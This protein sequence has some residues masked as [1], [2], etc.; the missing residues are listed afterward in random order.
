MIELFRKRKN[1]NF[2]D[3]KANPIIDGIEYSKFFNRS[4][5][6]CSC[7]SIYKYTVAKCFEIPGS[8]S[9]LLSDLTPDMKDLGFKDG[10]NMIEFD[11]HVEEKV[12]YYL[13]RPDELEILTRNG[14]R[15]VREKHTTEIRMK[16]FLQILRD[17]VNET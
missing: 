4:K 10:V 8:M 16:E 17:I 14:Y 13:N 5:I 3:K 15:F 7:S 1:F 9:A 11:N 12:D 6:S 2:K